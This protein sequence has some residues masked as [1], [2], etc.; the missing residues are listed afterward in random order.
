MNKLVT[1]PSNGHAEASEDGHGEKA[2]SDSLT[3][4]SDLLSTRF[5]VAAARRAA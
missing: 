3:E 1:V 2:E 5:A 4:G